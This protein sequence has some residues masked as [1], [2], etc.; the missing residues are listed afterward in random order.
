MVNRI[1]RYI[2]FAAQSMA[3]AMLGELVTENVEEMTS[4][5]RVIPPPIGVEST[6]EANGMGP[7]SASLGRLHG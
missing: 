2:N 1:E 3:K 4:P 5:E 6:L 7:C